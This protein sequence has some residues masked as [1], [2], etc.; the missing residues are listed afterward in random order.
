[1]SDYEVSWLLD[2][3]VRVQVSADTP[4]EAIRKAREAPVSPEHYEAVHA[5]TPLVTRVSRRMSGSMH[6]VTPFKVVE[7]Y[8]YG[9]HY[10]RHNE[11]GGGEGQFPDVMFVRALPDEL[12]DGAADAYYVDLRGLR[13]SNWTIGRRKDEV[14]W[15]LTGPISTGLYG[16]REEAMECA[17]SLLTGLDVELVAR[18]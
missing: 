14:L 17:H 15:R 5:S 6:V 9:E 11:R 3:Q 8:W 12:E 13:V 2:Q 1:M 7:D 10:T 16:S 4:E 18:V